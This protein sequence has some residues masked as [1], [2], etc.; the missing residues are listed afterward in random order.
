MLHRR[1]FRIFLF[2]VDITLDELD[3]TENEFHRQPR[4]EEDDVF[5]EDE[6]IMLNDYLKCHLDIHNLGILLMLVT[7]IRVGELVA[8][9]YTDFD[10]NTV[11]HIFRTETRFQDENGKNHHEIKEFP[12][13]PAGIPYVN[14][15]VCQRGNRPTNVGKHLHPSFWTTD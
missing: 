8:L 9:K 5:T 13:T 12:K 10:E 7:G 11:F 3:L 6:L 4:K 14:G 1:R 15:L 2:N